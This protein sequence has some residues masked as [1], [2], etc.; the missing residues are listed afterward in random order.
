MA[1]TAGALKVRDEFTTG[2]W[3]WKHG[4]HQAMNTFKYD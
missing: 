1:D 3:E 4:V 2:E